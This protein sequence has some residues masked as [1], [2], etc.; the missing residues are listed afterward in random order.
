[1]DMRGLRNRGPAD[2]QNAEEYGE[3]QP[4]RLRPDAAIALG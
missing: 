3:T 2:Q 1:M 4:K